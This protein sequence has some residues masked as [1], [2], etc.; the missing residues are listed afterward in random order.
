MK[1]PSSPGKRT[2]VRTGWSEAGAKSRV[3]PASS[4]MDPLSDLARLLA[5]LVVRD[6][7][8]QEAG[9]SPAVNNTYSADP[10]PDASRGPV[11]R[12]RTP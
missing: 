3:W 10:E 4:G 8:R 7:V 5:R 1:F 2:S 9:K 12:R 11:R 6:I